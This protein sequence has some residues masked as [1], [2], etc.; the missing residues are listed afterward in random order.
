MLNQ[1]ALQI[2]IGYAIL[3]CM[4]IACAGSGENRGIEALHAEN[5]FGQQNYQRGCRKRNRLG[6]P[7]YD[8]ENQ[9]RNGSMSGIDQARWNKHY[10][11]C[12]NDCNDLAIPPFEVCFTSYVNFLGS[13]GLFVLAIDL[14]RS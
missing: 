1:S 14:L 10:N 8:G 4:M 5:G 13:F 9:K 11:N 12:S 2:M 6:S 7:H 3:H